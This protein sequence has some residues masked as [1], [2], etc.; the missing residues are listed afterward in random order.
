MSRRIDARLARLERTAPLPARLDTAEARLAYCREN[1]LPEDTV[2]VGWP[3][4]FVIC[5]PAEE[6][7]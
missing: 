5:L 3:G 7:S 4:P 2:L 1:G 6:L